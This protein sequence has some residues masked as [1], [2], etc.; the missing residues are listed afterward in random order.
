MK[1]KLS[2]LSISTVIFLTGCGNGIPPKNPEELAIWNKS[3]IAIQECSKRNGFTN[4]AFYRAFKNNLTGKPSASFNFDYY[5]RY[6]AKTHEIWTLR[7]LKYLNLDAV[8]LARIKA[9]ELKEARNKTNGILTPEE[10]R[11]KKEQDLEN[12]DR[13]IS[14]RMNKE[15]VSSAEMASLEYERLKIERQE[16]KLNNDTERANELL[17]KIDKQN[18]VIR[19]IEAQD[20]ANEAFNGLKEANDRY[21][22]ATTKEEKA[23]AQYDMNA[24]VKRLDREKEKVS[25]Y[26]NELDTEYKNTNNYLSSGDE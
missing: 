11:R 1:N 22:S 9:Q 3:A 24:Y 5:E 6:C 7:E 15:G 8:S 17:E 20:K 25:N 26:Q 18:V 12:W 4:Q 16:A 14:N 19:Q 13:T 2:I 10:A 21:E 23:E